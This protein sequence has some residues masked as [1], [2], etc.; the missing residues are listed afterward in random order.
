MGLETSDRLQ[1]I[2][3]A[4][5]VPESEIREAALDRGLEALWQEVVIEEY[6][7]GERS[8]DEAIDIVGLRTLERAER[9]RDF[10]EHVDGN[11]G[12]S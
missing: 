1:A 4:R 8:R 12:D 11:R 6:L 10:V 3:D 9:E 7:D 5:D 2:A